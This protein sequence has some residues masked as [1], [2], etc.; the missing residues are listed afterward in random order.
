MELWDQPH[1]HWKRSIHIHGY[2]RRFPGNCK[3]VQLSPLGTLPERHVRYIHWG[4]DVSVLLAF[5]L[6]PPFCPRLG[7][8]VTTLIWL[9]SGLFTKTLI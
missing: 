1:A 3:S 6:Y 2:S 5:L 9:S 7:I 8:F 4:L